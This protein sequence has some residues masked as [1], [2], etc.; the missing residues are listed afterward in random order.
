MRNG[1][2]MVAVLTLAVGTLMEVSIGRAEKPVP[3]NVDQASGAIRVR[4]TNSYYIS[5]V[6]IMKKTNAIS[7]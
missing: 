2:M 5:E 4:P 1:M 6:K 7:T 3:S